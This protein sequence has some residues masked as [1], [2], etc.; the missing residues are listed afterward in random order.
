MKLCRKNMKWVALVVMAIV[1][2]G[3]G[4]NED[5]NTISS[6]KQEL[7]PDVPVWYNGNTAAQY[8]YDYAYTAGPPPFHFWTD[9]NC[10]NFASQA[11][12]AGLSGKTN[13]YD[14][15][16]I[17][18]D[19]KYDATSTKA[20]KW[21]YNGASSDGAWTSTTHLLNYAYHSWSETWGLKFAHITSSTPADPENLNADRVQ[22]GDIVFG[23]WYRNPGDYYHHTMIVMSVDP[24]TSKKPLDRIHVASQTSPTN[25]WTLRDFSNSA[26]G[27]AIYQIHQPLYFISR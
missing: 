22:R 6:L 5:I 16:A 26:P 25:H 17:T 1:T 27:V 13:P 24:D 7:T 14:L 19:Y 8:A 9:N 12:L 18:G 11:I 23:Q 15:N 21:F 20:I 3:C 10:V 4:P 2:I